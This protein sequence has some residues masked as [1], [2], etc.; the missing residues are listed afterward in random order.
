MRRRSLIALLCAAGLI[1]GC[2]SSSS[3]SSPLGTE[4]S[5]FPA[6]SPV[7]ITIATDPNGAAIQGVNSLLGQFPFASLGIGALKQKLQQSGVNYDGDLKPLFG[8]PVAVAISPTSL[9]NP[10]NLTSVSRS[11]AL[12]VWVTKDGDKLK[13]LLPKADSSVKSAGEHNGASLYVDASGD[14]FAIDGST[15]VAGASAGSVNAALDRHKSGGGMTEAEFKSATSTLPQDA[16]FTIFGDIGTLL[17][18]QGLSGA[19]QVPWIAAI[20]SY[21]EAISASSTGLRFSYHVDTSGAQLTDAELPFAPGTTAPALASGYPITFGIHDPARIAQFAESAE[22]VANP[23]SF[24]RFQ[25]RQDAIKAKSGVN[26]DSLISLLTGD[27]IIASDL[28]NTMGRVTVSDPTAAAN[29]LDKLSV[30]VKGNTLRKSAG[31]WSFVTKKS[32]LPVVLVGNQLVVGK[33]PVAALK[34]FATAPT[35][36]AAGAQGSVAFRISLTQ[37]IAAALGSSGSAGSTAQAARSVLNQLSD[38]TGWSSV[39]PSGLTGDATLGVR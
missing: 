12:V 24:T 39:S 19:R 26:L 22:R 2:G 7:V 13:S 29:V 5:Y 18:Q 36:P 37:L 31:G 34:A 27:L 38:F 10:G 17:N 35:S 1:A 25:A 15:L 30:N 8:N 14:A 11:S 32:V 21:A 33:A 20:H 16:V 28:H 6:G 23:V 4:L 9:T 3:S